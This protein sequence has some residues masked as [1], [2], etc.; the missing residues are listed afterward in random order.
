MNDKYIVHFISK[1]KKK[2]VNFIENKLKEKE[3]NDLVPSY[4]NILTVLYDNDGILSMKEIGNLIGKDKS[5][6]T[7][8]CNKLI[9]LGYIEKEKSK[10]DKRVTYIKITQKAK[11]IESKF[12]DI[13]DEVY[14]RAYH[15]FSLEE[16]KV[17]LK[18]LK[19]LNNNF[20]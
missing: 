17:F 7:A 6:V 19:K 11:N 4:G 2:M 14:S 18:L 5:T 1:T 12:N 3:L 13:S 15:N 10:K 20:D 9:K 8:L 16:K